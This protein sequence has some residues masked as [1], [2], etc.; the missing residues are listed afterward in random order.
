MNFK[1]LRKKPSPKTKEE[2]LKEFLIDNGFN[3][4]I[5]TPFC[6]SNLDQ[7]KSISIDNPLDSNK[8]YLRVNLENSLIENL[9]FNENRQRDS[10]KLFEISDLYIK[11]DGISSRKVLGLLVSGRVGENY[12]DFSKKL[13]TKYLQELFKKLTLVLILTMLKRY[14]EKHKK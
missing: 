11:N 7:D 5:N 4:V 9:I 6:N 3:E 2:K 1:L 10:I 13:N 14:Q 8:K 12:V